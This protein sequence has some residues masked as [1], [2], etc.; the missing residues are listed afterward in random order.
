MAAEARD[1][2]APDN[3]DVEIGR[4]VRVER[5]A[6]GLSQTDLGNRIGVTF[7]QVEKYESGANRISMGRLTRIGRVFGVNVTYL[8]G[9]T[10]CATPAAA[11]DPKERAKFAEAAGMLGRI[12]ATRLLKA[13]L[14]IPEDPPQLRESIVT[15]VEFAECHA[16]QARGNRSKR[17]P[18]ARRHRQDNL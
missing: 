18:R 2:R 8:L 17:V 6:R 4:R 9:A 13:F 16:T 12:G 11:S 15:L 1:P 5:I 3:V 10:R 14:A 7:Q